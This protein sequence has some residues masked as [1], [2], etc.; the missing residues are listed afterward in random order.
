[1]YPQPSFSSYQY[2]NLV[3]SLLP[4]TAVRIILN[5]V[6]DSLLFHPQTGWYIWQR[7]NFFFKYITI[8]SLL[9]LKN[10]QWFYGASKAESR[11]RTRAQSPLQLGDHFLWWQ[12]LCL[13]CW[14]SLGCLRESWQELYFY[15]SHKEKQCKVRLIA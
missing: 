15:K 3:S 6:P 11:V 14:R 5:Q 4:L 9:C 8:V 2:G 1:M 7:V 13:T 10:E 12:E